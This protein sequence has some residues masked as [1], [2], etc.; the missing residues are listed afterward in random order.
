MIRILPRPQHIEE[1]EGRLLLDYHCRITMDSSCPS[2]VFFYASQLAEQLKKS[3]GIELL[4]DRR[5]S[6]AHKGIVLCMSGE[7]GITRENKKEKEAYR[8]EI[9]PEGVTVCAAE[10]EGL[11]NSVQT[12]R[13]LIIQYGSSLPCL[14][15]EDYPEL[16]VRGWFMDVTRGRIPKMTYLKELAIDAV[17]I[18][19]ISCIFILSTPFYLMV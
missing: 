8:L 15:I 9:T 16:S 12:L 5:T 10:K 11:F 13:Q 14:Y 18:R 19:L 4:I 2:E 7:A 6:G 3:S 17:F 1:R